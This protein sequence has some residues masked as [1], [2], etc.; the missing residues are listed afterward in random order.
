MTTKDITLPSGIVATLKTAMTY[1]EHT[2]IEAILLA[3]AK[4]K[5][6]PLTKEYENEF[7]GN[8]TTDWN[9]KKLLTFVVKLMDG[10]KQVPL[11]R[12]TFEELDYPDGK[13]LEET[14]EE[15]IA[16]LKKK[17]EETKKK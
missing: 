9:F 7:T 8:A 1:G 10:D 6:N 17:V 5:V 14:I 4:G 11:N 16:D 2:Q 3:G 13:F 12:K 15:I